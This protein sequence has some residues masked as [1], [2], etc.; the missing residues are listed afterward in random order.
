MV[1]EFDTDQNF[2]IIFFYCCV[3]T[4][5]NTFILN[6]HYSYGSGYDN[7]GQGQPSKQDFNNYSTGNG[8]TGKSS[9]AQGSSGTGGPGKGEYITS[10]FPWVSKQPNLILN[11]RGNKE[12]GKIIL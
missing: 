2:I 9:G 4:T 3:S 10:A 12:R 7:L 8:T 6:I 1:S 5:N 11:D